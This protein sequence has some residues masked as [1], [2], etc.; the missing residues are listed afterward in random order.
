MPART[1]PD[2]NW[3]LQRARS[4]HFS[5]YRLLNGE[6]VLQLLQVSNTVCPATA[7]NALS[8]FCM[9]TI[10]AVNF[11]P[12]QLDLRQGF[13]SLLVV[14]FDFRSLFSQFFFLHAKQYLDVYALLRNFLNVIS[15]DPRVYQLT[16]CSSA[17]E[18][19]VQFRILV[20]HAHYTS[21]PPQLSVWSGLNILL[22]CSKIFITLLTDDGLPAALT[23][24]FGRETPSLTTFTGAGVVYCR[25]LTCHAQTVCFR[26]PLHCCPL[27]SAV[28][29]A[30]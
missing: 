2:S 13:S 17:P 6:H 3:S 29:G 1:V 21:A 10:F 8:I 28:S 25:S 15:S 22:S 14:F 19:R 7:Q 4:S 9:F 26:C 18:V 23:I 24:I 27:G 11:V 16:I 20:A 30:T 5:T 12:F